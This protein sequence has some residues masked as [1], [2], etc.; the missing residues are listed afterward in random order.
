VA[1][2]MPLIVRINHL[3]LV[4]LDDENLARISTQDPFVLKVGELERHAG[5]RITEI[6]IVFGNEHDHS[7][8]ASL[9]HQGRPIDA[10]KYATRGYTDKP[11]DRMPIVRLSGERGP[12]S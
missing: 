4:V 7:Q 5:G 8:I 10:L 11:G 6:A 3:A 2:L 12:L 9:V 1:A